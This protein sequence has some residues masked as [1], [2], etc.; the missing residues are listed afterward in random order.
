M[1][2]LI[3]HGETSSSTSRL[4]C[5]SSSRQILR[6]KGRPKLRK[7]YCRAGLPNDRDMEAERSSLVAEEVIFMMFQLDLD[8][9][10]QRCLNVEEYE[11]AQEVRRKRNKVDEAI[12][13]MMAKKAERA[14]GTT[15]SEET[16]SIAD[17]ASEGLRLRS[18]LQRAID[19]ERYQDAAQF[20]DLLVE[21][22][23]ES[24]RAQALVIGMEDGQQP[25]FRLGQRVLHRNDGFRGLIVGW[26]MK[27]CESEEWMQH[28]RVTDMK[29]QPYYHVLVDVRDCEPQVGLPPTVYVPQER[30]TAPEIEETSKSWIEAYGSEPMYHPYLDALFLGQDGKGDY[31]PCRHLR[32]KFSVRRRDVYRS[33][34]EPK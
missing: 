14:A 15:T 2:F 9:Q 25:L 7:L 31:I 6:S 16:L 21:L 34:E 10:L 20:R 17:L 33:G 11:Q 1:N 12:K 32:E 22:E 26:D 29:P 27:C 5:Q 24:K 18:E 4:S 8:I 28:A 13:S 23:K 3:R 30:L 19:Q